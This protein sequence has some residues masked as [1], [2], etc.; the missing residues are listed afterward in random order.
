[1][2]GPTGSGRVTFDVKYRVFFMFQAAGVFHGDQEFLGIEMHGHVFRGGSAPNPK[3]SKGSFLAGEGL[4]LGH[5]IPLAA[6]REDSVTKTLPNMQGVGDGRFVIEFC[7]GFLPLF[8]KFSG[9][10][11]LRRLFCAF[12]PH[13]VSPGE[14]SYTRSNS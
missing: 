12:V 3:I 11:L 14:L 8:S 7:F 13:A 5:S 10:K 6:L 2:S 9:Q 4:F 1:M